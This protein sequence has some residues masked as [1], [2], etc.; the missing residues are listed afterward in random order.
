[1]WCAHNLISI[2]EP[3]QPRDVIKEPPQLIQLR[4]PLT[5]EEKRRGKI[6]KQLSYPIT[7]QIL[8]MEKQIVDYHHLLESNHICV[9]IPAGEVLNDKS[10]KLIKEFS[11]SGLIHSAW[12]NNNRN[13]NSDNT[14]PVPS[15]TNTKAFFITMR[16]YWLYRVFTGSFD[17]GGRYYGGAWQNLPEQ[18]R[19]YIKI[20]LEPTIEL[21]YSNFNVRLLY[22]KEGA[23]YSGDA[24]TCGSIPRK[25][26]KTAT[27]ALL[28][29]HS[30][31]Y[32]YVIS[33]AFR[34]KELH[35]KYPGCL[36]M[37]NVN[38]IID[39]IHDKHPTI[40][41]YFASG[42]A[43]ETQRLDSTILSNILDRFIE[44]NIVAL[45][46]HDSLI[47]QKRYEDY[48]RQAMVEE[49]EKIMKFKPVIG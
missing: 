27:I 9:D 33:K 7:E 2:F 45:P 24:Y 42:K 1:M 30:K 10:N 40:T 34:D 13:T 8:L 18:V 21:D 17:L 29:C 38:P 4:E 39:A 37:K 32:Y 5:K 43:L 20:N 44:Q 15:P 14:P 11:R 31:N 48:L 16:Y 19:K 23:D 25:L 6:A 35:H 3:I 41:K 47:V 49:Y 36:L 12:T 46:V 28:N 26:F 22:H